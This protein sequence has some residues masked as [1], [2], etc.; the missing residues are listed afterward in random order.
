MKLEV[1]GCNLDECSKVYGKHSSI[2][3]S[4]KQLCAGGEDGRGTCNGDSGDSIGDV[5]VHA[6]IATIFYVFTNR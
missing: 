3:L 4:H 2:H 5:F 1:N 6:N